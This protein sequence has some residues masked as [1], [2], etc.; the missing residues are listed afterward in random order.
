[1]TSDARQWGPAAGLALVLVVLLAIWSPWSGDDGSDRSAAGVTVS[2]VD[3]GG[4]GRGDVVRALRAAPAPPAR[5]VTVTGPDDE[6]MTMAGAD[7]GVRIDLAATATRVMDADE[8]ARLAPV[9][10]ADDRRVGAFVKRVGDELDHRAD[11]ADI[12]PRDGRLKVVEEEEG[13][14]TDRQGLKRMLTAA[15]TRPGGTRTLEAPGETLKPERTKANLAE[16]IPRYIVVD[17]SKNELRVYK[18][19]KLDETYDIS[20]GKAGNDTPPGRYEVTARD[21]DPPWHAPD[22]EWAGELAGQTIPPGDPRNPLK[23]RWIGL[24]DGVGIHGTAE[25]EKIGSEASHGCIRMR[26]EDVKE[27]FRDTPMKTP[28]YIS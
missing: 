13:F 8:D 5:S 20:V 24:E 7:A 12:D 14:R 16:K 19:L 27:L 17:R 11:D 15:L 22:A 21:V 10:A 25:E 2:G 26:V 4:K 9:M 18:R 6:R 28:V 3:V 23:A 1:M